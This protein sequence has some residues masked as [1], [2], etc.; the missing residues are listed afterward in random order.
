MIGGV[1]QLNSSIRTRSPESTIE[2]VRRLAPGLGIV[3]VTDTT[4]LDRVGIPV[5][6]SIRPDA[7]PGSLCVSAGKGLTPAEALAGA[8]MEALELAWA[9]H[10]RARL[11]YVR[12]TPHDVLDGRVRPDAIHDF[13]IPPGPIALDGPL[14]CVVASDLVT[15]A[16]VLVPAELVLFPM[17]AELDGQR[18]FGMSHGNGL[19]SGNTTDEATVH[20]L[21][22]LIERDIVAFSTVRDDSRRIAPESWPP[23]LR[24]LHDRLAHDGFELYLRA[25]PSAFGIPCFWALLHEPG[26]RDAVHS[27][28]GCNLSRAVAATRAIVEAA[29]ARLTVIHGGRDDLPAHFAQL[30]GR[31]ETDRA[32]AF[33]RIVAAAA[34]ASRTAELHEVDDLTAVTTDLETSLGTLVA[35]LRDRGFRWILRVVY[36]PPDYPV[37]VV[38]V[39][40]PGLELALGTTRQVGAR[41]RQFRDRI[42]EENAAVRGS[43]PGTGTATR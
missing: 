3:R 12:A 31:S 25:L 39:I 5:A 9:E 41:L 11:E 22:E 4:R 40:V 6:A 30:A 14:D 36:T 29:Q 2:I 27:G 19:C 7:V 15:G 23:A 42:A 13:A 28:Y 34:D 21:C 26:M 32:R 33:E 20:G 16:R 24:A 8:Y 38:R 10:R 43:D 37:Q 35:I 1:V 18:V 17:P